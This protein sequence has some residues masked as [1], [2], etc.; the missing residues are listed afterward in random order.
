MIP[1]KDILTHFSVTVDET[2]VYLALLAL[3]TANVTEIAKK[4][5]KNRTATYFHVRKLVEK[6]LVQSPGRAGC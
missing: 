2:D 5:K 1:I 3:G 4:I 6:E